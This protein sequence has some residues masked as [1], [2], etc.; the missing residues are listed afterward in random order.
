LIDLLLAA[1]PSNQI[2]KLVA[3]PTTNRIVWQTCQNIR[4]SDVTRMILGFA[5]RI[6]LEL[7]VL[8][9]TFVPRFES[10]AVSHSAGSRQSHRIDGAIA[11]YAAVVCGRSAAV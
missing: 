4:N 8:D 3:R 6:I 7:S 2:S 10:S 5:A 11:E 1:P 9:G